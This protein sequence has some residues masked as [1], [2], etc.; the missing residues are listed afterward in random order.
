Y[1]SIKELS[2]QKSN[3]Y[4][5][6]YLEKSRSYYS[7]YI[8]GTWSPKSILFNKEV[9]LI[10]PGNTTEIHKKG[11]E[12]FILKKKPIVVVLNNLNKIDESLIDFRIACHPIRIFSDLAKYKTF[13]QPLI[14]PIS[15][16]KKWSKKKIEFPTFDFGLQVKENIFKY[17]DKSC[18][19]PYPLAMAYALAILNS[20]NSKLIYLVGFDGYKNGDKRSFQVEHI[21][22]IY[23]KG[24]DNKKII[25]LTETSYNIEKSSLYSFL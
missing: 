7:E 3:I 8:A 18:I 25:S 17:D 14:A 12:E 13:S 16:L 2:N 1:A 24:M 4:K 22:N 6:S 15:S 20:G 5:K 23:N 9:L 11:V 10:A 21:W 19:I